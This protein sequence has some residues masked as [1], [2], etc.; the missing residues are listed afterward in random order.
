MP[1]RLADLMFGLPVVVVPEVQ[2]LPVVFR[3]PRVFRI[4]DE[5]PEVESVLV[6]AAP[7]A[8]CQASRRRL[9]GYSFQTGAERQARFA[10]REQELQRLRDEEVAWVMPSQAVI[11]RDDSLEGL[12][13]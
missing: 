3:E 8:M 9:T 5:V 1:V 12:G 13:I 4:L 11:E 6:V 7:A 10:R 2:V